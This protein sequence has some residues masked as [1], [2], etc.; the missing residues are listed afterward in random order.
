MAKHLLSILLVALTFVGCNPTKESLKQAEQYSSA[1]MHLDAFNRY[2]SIYRN[3]PKALEA[4]IGAKSTGNLLVSKYFAEVQMLM[5]SGQYESALQALDHAEQFYNE[6][7]WLNLE[8]PMLGLVSRTEIRKRIADNYFALA[9]N[10]SQEERWDA[11]QM[12][13]DKV[14]R[15]DPTHQEAQYLEVMAQIVPDYRRGVKAMELG[16][17]QEALSYFEIVLDKDADFANVM[18]LYKECVDASKFTVAYVHVKE[19]R[20]EDKYNEC[21]S[22]FVYEEI[23]ETESPLIT[24]VSRNNLQH[25]I[26]EQV[27]SMGGVIDEESVVEAG[28]LLGAEYLLLGEIDGIDAVERVTSVRNPL[29]F[30]IGS[31]G[32]IKKSGGKNTR[33]RTLRAVYKFQ[34]VNSETGQIAIAKT[35]PFEHRGEIAWSSS[36]DRLASLPSIWEDALFDEILSIANGSISRNKSTTRTTNG[37]LTEEQQLELFFEFVAKS[38]AEELND[39]A[40]NRRIDH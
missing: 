36:Q 22:S 2:V 1:G 32:V 17:Y 5:S 6:N 3:N 18:S 19:E 40:L 21:L 4:H 9:E 16:L 25:L 8:K 27:L 15:Y 24:L 11:V 20:I 26:H 23:L 30:N 35:L 39:F 10:A 14:F 29:A 37:E 31:D 12:Y 13:L 7:Q 33:E 28:N 38:V 34:L